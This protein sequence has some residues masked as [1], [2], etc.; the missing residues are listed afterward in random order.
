MANAIS[1]DGVAKRFGNVIA[2]DGVDFE[3]ATGTV[4]GLLGPNGAGKTT[5]VRVLATILDPDRGRAEVLGLDVVK[6]AR[7]LRPLIGLAGQN[8]AV[9]ANLTGMENLRL[10]GRL[11]HLGP[12]MIKERS[13]ELLERFGLSGAADRTV[14]TYSGGM[15]RRL[16]LAAAL[17]HRPPV[18]FLDEPTTGLDIQGRS[19][20]WEM[21]RELVA[22]NT[23]VLLTTQYL[24]EADRLADRV[25][26]IHGGLVIAND[27]PAALKAKLGGTVT[28]LNFHDEATA[29][30]AR[31]RLARQFDKVERERALVRLT[32]AAGAGELI[33]VLR[34]LDAGGLEPASLTV[35]DPSLDDVFLALTGRHTETEVVSQETSEVRA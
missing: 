2:L 3:V 11:S 4:F 22:A 5:M 35:R 20:L 33:E 6:Q 14:R 7:E 18:L 27:T 8:A 29:I 12:G 13:G 9:D 10:I 24:E 26:V 21:I 25:A 31:D 17:V 19:E 16:D 28:E 15:R 32:L 23:T 1:V 30:Q 34:A